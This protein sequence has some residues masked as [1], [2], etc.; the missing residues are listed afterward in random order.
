MDTLKGHCFRG[1][2]N[3]KDNINVSFF[4]SLRGDPSVVSL[5]KGKNAVSVSMPWRYHGAQKLQLI[6][7]SFDV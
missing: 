7:G 4:C 6:V 3:N 1:Q 2:A 5:T